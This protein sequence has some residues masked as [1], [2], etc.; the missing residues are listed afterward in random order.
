VSWTDPAQASKLLPWH[1]TV[2]FYRV[3]ALPDVIRLIATARAL[4]KLVIY[5]I[6]D[7][8]FD[9]MYPPP[10]ETYGGYVGIPE[11]RSLMQGMAL[12][13]AAAKL[14]DYAIASTEPLAHALQGLVR[15]GKCFLHRNGLDSQN[16]VP[17][18]LPDPAKKGYVNLFYGS[19]TKAHNSDF[20]NEAL[21]A[22]ERIL[23]EHPDVKLTIVGYL[24]LPAEFL[25]LYSK[26][27][28]TIAPVKDVRAYWNY[29]SLSDIN[30]AVLT[31]DPMTDCKSELKWF[32]AACFG[33]PS[34]VSATQNYLDVLHEG[35]DALIARTVEDWYQALKLLLTQPE[36]RRAM[37][38]SARQRVLKEYSVPALSIR[39]SQVLQEAAD[40]HDARG[41]PLS[42]IEIKTE[43]QEK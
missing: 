43:S 13:R 33:V 26:Q 2:I 16:I 37:G 15:S 10:I 18:K 31:P 22:I 27:I 19:G 6:D 14:C 30:L 38:L 25:E 20:T 41:K 5:E 3:P 9:P 34:V 39:L 1:D 40:L 42:M 17:H 4:G 11:Y 36:K 7:L 32:E 28:I 21:P 8:L 23:Q 35:E 29:L 12:M 24:E